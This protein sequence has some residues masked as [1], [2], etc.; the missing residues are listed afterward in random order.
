MSAPLPS[1][2][3]RD[4]N[5]SAMKKQVVINMVPPNFLHPGHTAIRRS[6]ILPVPDS[7]NKELADFP[8]HFGGIRQQHHVEGRGKR[9]QFSGH[10]TMF[11]KKG[12]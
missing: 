5:F 3:S 2:A 9:E 10:R 12:I 8:L 4:M 6:H 7:E 11:L 1:L